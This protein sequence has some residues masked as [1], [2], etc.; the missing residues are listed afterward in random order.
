MLLLEVKG[1]YGFKPGW[2]CSSGAVCRIQPAPEEK[3]EGAKG[4]GR[5]RSAARGGGEL[6][7]FVFKSRFKGV[8]QHQCPHL[9][10]VFGAPAACPWDVPAVPRTLG[11][12]GARGP[13]GA[14]VAKRHRHC[15]GRWLP[16]E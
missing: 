4:V 5:A 3:L 1:C 12:R 13:R 8:C 14:P 2:V 9:G 10:L 11:Q 7:S 6:E 16:D 15:S